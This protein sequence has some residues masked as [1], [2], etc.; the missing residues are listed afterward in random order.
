LERRVAERRH[1]ILLTLVAQGA[2]DL[3]DEVIGLFDQAISARESHARSKSDQALTERAKQGEAR[4]LLLEVILSV[5]ADPSIPDE[6]VGS[7]LRD[8][9]GMAALRQAAASAWPS[10]PRDYGR[11]SAM[12]ASY[13][14]LRQFT[15]NVLTAI[16]FHGGPGTGDL[17]DAVALLQGLNHIGGR[18]VPDGAPIGFVPA[19]A[20][21]YLAKAQREGDDAAFRHYWE[22]CVLLGLRDGP[23]SGDVHVPG[24][25][26]YADPATYLFTR[27]EWAPRQAEFCALVG[28]SSDAKHALAEDKQELREALADLERVL[29]AT[30]SNEVGAVRLDE[31]GKLVIPPLSAEDIP[32][33][34]KALK[35]ELAAMLPF[36][37]IASLLVELDHR[38]AF[39]SC[40]VHAGG[41]KQARSA[42]TK[43]NILA[44]LIA[45]ATNRGLT[46]MA[47]ACGV[48]Y[49]VL[50]WTEEW[51][52]REETLREASRDAR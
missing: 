40:F 50:A 29:A 23:R 3:L 51:Y 12:D 16:D 19:R 43:R 41:H 4:Q 13:T 15:P 30:K 5:L 1:P 48:P 2:I 6:Q 36:A 34:A 10:L 21:E 11:L 32:A 7:L 9:I 17:M 38:T 33:E 31:E 46:R 20:A 26:R 42:E 52:V 14:Y 47:E 8:T 39:L 22:L 18:K 45:S 27:E 35:E 37:P 49:D 44:V 24:S 28:K 25:R